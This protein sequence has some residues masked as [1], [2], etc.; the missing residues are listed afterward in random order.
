MPRGCA[1]AHAGPR[2]TAVSRGYPLAHWAVHAIRKPNARIH[3]ALVTH[4]AFR[5]RRSRCSPAPEVVDITYVVAGRITRD[6]ILP[7]VGLPLLDAP[8][9]SGLYA[10]GGVRTWHDRVGLMARVGE[11]YPRRWLKELETQGVDTAGVTILEQDV[12]VRAF[13]AYDANLQSTRSS[14]VSQFA[15][16]KLAF[17]K[18]LLGYQT[19]TE[20][21]ADAR[22]PDVLAPSAIEIPVPYREALAVHLCPL[23]FASHVQLANAFR[24][25]SANTLTVDP[26]P[27]YMKPQF[28][29]D[30]RALLAGASAFLP[31][32]E[33]LRGSVLGP[34]VRPLGDAIRRG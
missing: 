25:S 18:A 28:L 4:D 6:Y 21:Q 13:Y 26:S 33:E 2:I 29:R 5:L 11:D 9:G 34:N 20:A 24:A 23:D 12:D 3:V 22:K 32:E 14:P 10:C 17:P 30:L 15:R 8:G 31:S 1:G 27:A 16:R 19:P 7:P